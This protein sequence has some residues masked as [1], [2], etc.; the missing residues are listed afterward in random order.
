MGWLRSRHDLDDERVL[1]GVTAGVL[2]LVGALVG[3]LAELLPG[4]PTVEPWLFVALVGVV[5]LYGVASIAGWIDWK[6]VSVNQH[7]LASAMLM[8]VLGIV[9]WATGGENSYIAPVLVLPL[10]HV[11]YFFRPLVSGLL[12]AELVLV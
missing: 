12:V 1:I 5:A 9:L 7:A 8:P 10:L 11:A 2:W 4:A 6:Q 3:A